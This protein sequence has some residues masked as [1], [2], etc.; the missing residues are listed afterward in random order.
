MEAATLSPSKGALHHQLGHGGQVSE[1]DQVTR[2]L[3]V[4][5]V[6]LDFLLNQ[7]DALASTLQTP[8]AT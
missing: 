6:S 4:P 3:E 5:V 2:Q 1:L 8:M 7:V